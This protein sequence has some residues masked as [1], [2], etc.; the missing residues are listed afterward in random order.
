VN[1]H[2]LEL[3]LIKF[4]SSSQW[5]MGMILICFALLIFQ[6]EIATCFVLRFSVRSRQLSRYQALSLI[7][8]DTNGRKDY[9]FCPSFLCAQP[10][11]VTL[12]STVLDQVLYQMEERLPHVLCFSVRSRQ[13]SRYQALSL[14]KS[15]TNGQ[16]D[17]DMFCP[18]FLCAQPPA[19]TLSRATVDQV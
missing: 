2:F 10:P 15:D 14:I 12:S 4:E 6:R 5:A 3:P 11:A 13:M 19:V 16:I 7:K 1:L 18:S 17:Y 9:V 8:S